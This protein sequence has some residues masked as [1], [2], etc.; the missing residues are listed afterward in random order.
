[1]SDGVEKFNGN[2]VCR[3]SSS[4][5]S[6]SAHT[7]IDT[8]SVVGIHNENKPLSVLIVMSPQWAN[9]IL[10]NVVNHEMLLDSEHL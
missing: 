2:H 4:Q 9:F 7:R 10:E 8:I 1:M 3:S 5:Y 6:T